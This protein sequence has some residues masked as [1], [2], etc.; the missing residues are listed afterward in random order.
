MEV[1]SLTHPFLISRLSTFG[2]WSF[3]TKHLGSVLTL[4]VA[5]CQ[6]PPLLL[7]L[8]LP[9]FFEHSGCLA[10]PSLLPS[11]QPSIPSG[12]V[13]AE[14]A[15][16]ASVVPLALSVVLI[17][18]AIRVTGIKCP[19]TTFCRV[20]TVLHLCPF[21]W[22]LHDITDEQVPGGPTCPQRRHYFSP[23]LGGKIY[24]ICP[25]EKHGITRILV[26]S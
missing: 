20:F 8:H 7:L 3:T 16:G 10:L 2:R 21:P 18:V 9:V 13:S 25:S 24:C 6:G 12:Q 1:V 19:K 17:S 23:Q 11:L 5:A 26:H 4:S 14:R 15:L 22:S